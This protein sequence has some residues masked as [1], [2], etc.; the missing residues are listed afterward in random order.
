[1]FLSFYGFNIKA[2]GLTF[3]FVFKTKGKFSFGFHTS[4]CSDEQERFVFHLT[5][6]EFNGIQAFLVYS[7]TVLD[8]SRAELEHVELDLRGVYNLLMQNIIY[9]KSDGCHILFVVDKSHIDEDVRG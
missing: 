1:M 6:F 8:R 3:Q 2:K 7:V 9:K 4:G 5:N